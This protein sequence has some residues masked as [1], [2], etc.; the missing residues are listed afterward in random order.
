MQPFQDEH[1][2][3]APL[4]TKDSKWNQTGRDKEVGCGGGQEGLMTV[5]KDCEN[6]YTKAIVY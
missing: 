2:Q 3:T 1:I 5:E 6:R 4:L